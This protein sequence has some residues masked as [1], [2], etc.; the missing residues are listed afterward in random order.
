MYTQLVWYTTQL[1]TGIHKVNQNVCIYMYTYTHA[2]TCI[3]VDC[4]YMYIVHVQSNL[5]KWTLL[6]QKKVSWLERCPDFRGYN[7]HKQGVWNSQMYWGVLISLI[8]Y[9]HVYTCMCVHSINSLL[10]SDA[11]CHE[12]SAKNSIILFEDRLFSHISMNNL[13]IRRG[14]IITHTI[15]ECRF[16]SLSI[17]LIINI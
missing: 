5:S 1:F 17:L 3:H 8:R 15:S 9:I 2:C 7:V 12:P 4:I 13:D 14:G 10:D 11:G 16:W 6:G